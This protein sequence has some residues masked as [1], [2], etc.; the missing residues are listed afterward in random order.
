MRLRARV[1]Y[2][3]TKGGNAPTKPYEK[4]TCLF[5]LLVLALPLGRWSMQPIAIDRCR[6]APA[7]HHQSDQNIL[8]QYLHHLAWVSASA[9]CFVLQR[10]VANS[11]VILM[12]MW[13]TEVS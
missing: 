11:A 1:D 7:T 10:P 13:H 6:P 4:D 2:N 12:S 9:S 8:A 5:A 3:F